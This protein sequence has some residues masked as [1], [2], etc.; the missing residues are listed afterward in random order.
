MRVETAGEDGGEVAGA[1]AT[2]E[3]RL[4]MQH[5]AR[6]DSV[7]DEPLDLGVERWPG[8]IFGDAG[9]GGVGAGLD[10]GEALRSEDGFGSDAERVEVFGAR[11]AQQRDRV[12]FLAAGAG[13]RDGGVVALDHV[14]QHLDRG[15]WADGVCVHDVVV[16]ADADVEV[17]V[18]GV[19]A[20]GERDVE[21]LPGF[22][23]GQDGVAGVD[24]LA[25]GGVDGAGVAEL[26]VLGDVVGGQGDAPAG[27]R[28]PDVE[29][30]VGTDRGD[31]PAVAVGDPVGGRQR[32]ATV[33]AAGDDRR[34]RR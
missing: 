13:G 19:P 26:D 32:E 9:D 18:V 25:L 2:D 7:E 23:A 28:V 33:V 17:E 3:H 34:R 15:R 31:G 10:P 29:C 5:L 11:L 20:A 27:L 24:G 6:I 8:R 22:A 12:A 1:V 30:A 4:V 21:Q 14:G 16:A